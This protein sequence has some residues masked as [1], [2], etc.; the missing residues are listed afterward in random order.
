[1]KLTGIGILK[2]NG[3]DKPLFVGMAT[4][5]SNFGYF[6]RASVREGLHFLVRTIVQR[7]QPGQ[8]Q[9][10]KAEGYLCH[11]H[12][13]DSGMAGVVVADEEYPT[14]AAFSVITKVLDDQLERFGDSWQR[15]TADEE[16]SPD[17][18]E[19]ALLKYQDHTQADKL[20]KIQKDLDETKIVLHQT[21]ESVL[22]RGEKLD[23]LVDKSNDLSLA[24][25]MFYKQARKSNSCCTYM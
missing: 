2:W 3:E 20:A 5:V 22:K 18:L 9:S 1:M 8:R 12:V 23:A 6:Q 11:V 13:R 24:S 17:V 21:I 16:A 19:P 25:Q 7:T 4:D 15:V 14:T 10:V